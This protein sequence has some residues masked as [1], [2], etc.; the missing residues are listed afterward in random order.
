MLGP[1]KGE[2]VMFGL[3]RRSDKPTLE[4]EKDQALVLFELLSRWIDD[5]SQPTPSAE[6]FQSPAELVVL[7]QIDEKLKAALSEPLRIDYLEILRAARKRLSDEFVVADI[8]H[9]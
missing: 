8:L 9:D 6:C 2:V 4:L 5:H 3:G 7:K 1:Q